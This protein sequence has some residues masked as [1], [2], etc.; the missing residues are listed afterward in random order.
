MTKAKADRLGDALV[1]AGILDG[2]RPGKNMAKAT[3]GEHGS[4]II[5][6]RWHGR[7]SLSGIACEH[8]AE[9]LIRDG[10]WTV[11]A[12]NACRHFRGESVKP[13]RLTVKR[14]PHTCT[15]C[16]QQAA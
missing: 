12:I 8:V 4:V 9:A 1:R 5:E 3:T 14:C 15:A 16:Q 13:V 2:A 7:D 10:R 6:G 11:K